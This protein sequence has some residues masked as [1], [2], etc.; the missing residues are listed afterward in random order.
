[1]T[2]LRALGVLLALAGAVALGLVWL[3]WPAWWLAAMLL[4]PLGSAVALVSLPR[5]D[6]GWVR[7]CARMLAVG[8]L[9]L[10][11]VPLAATT[12]LQAQ[13]FTLEVPWIEA[14][15]A[16]LALQVDGISLWFIIL[17]NLV[18]VVA[19]QVGW[20]SIQHKLKEFA[21]ALAL[22]Q[23]T[24]TL[25]F[26]ATDLLLF[27]LAWE[28]TLLPALLLI[29]LWGGAGAFRAAGK[30]FLF[31]LAGSLAM[32]LA[33]AFIAWR[34]AA[35]AGTPSLLLS[36]LGRMVLP[37]RE[38]AWVFAAFALAFAVKVPL[39]PLH[40]WLPD[41]YR[42]A[43]TAVTLV[44]SAVL[45]KLGAFGFLRWALPLCPLAAHYAMPTLG[46]LAVVGIVYG[47][48]CAW[49]QRDLKSMLA[50]SS[51]S[52]LGFVMLGI[53]SL[54]SGAIAGAILQVV[55][56][57]LLSAGLFAFVAVLA[58]RG[59]AGAF[60]DLSG[61]AAAMPMG[62]VLLT[63]LALGAVGLPGTSAFVA[64]FMVLS[65]AAVAGA[66]YPWHLALVGGA[67]LG[68]LFGA[69]YVLRLIRHVIM[70]PP[71]AAQQTW[72][73]LHPGERVVLWPLAL[74]VLAIGLYPRLVLDSVEP[75]VKRYRAELLE[76]RG[77]A[78]SDDAPR[79]RPAIP[80]QTDAGG[81]LALWQR[82]E[83]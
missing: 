57:G 35:L 76:A 9:G 21:A 31:T 30:F 43:P 27:Y 50:Y 72:P 13:A 80:V 41:T 33:V 17:A 83:P 23:A 73:D 22:L 5:Q 15:G 37:Y 59:H 16:R 32:L 40:G 68:V 11:L 77:A 36:D 55:S 46:A 29:G 65:G 6:P 60:A 4:W 81:E 25:A 75:A 63:V 1:M 66:Y 14:L 42:Q 79:L 47:A 8:G 10:G 51:L 2:R 12:A 53:F 82:G 74:L 64:E 28:L 7:A 54:N 18:H 58:R 78:A 26:A 24:L 67:L 45:A 56:H 52:H 3:A 44:L 61:L 34:Y 71:E 49:S 20:G 48:F 19:L 39:L 62:A 38:Q 70:G 69:V